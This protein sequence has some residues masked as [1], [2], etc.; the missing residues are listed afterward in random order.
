MTIITENGE[1]GVWIKEIEGEPEILEDST[2]R[3]VQ[4]LLSTR[5]FQNFFNQLDFQEEARKEATQRL[6][7]IA[8]KYGPACYMIGYPL[9]NR[10][11]GKKT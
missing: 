3:L 10:Q 8:Q 4:S 9:R 6:L 1:S 7:T 5:L 2:G 11:E